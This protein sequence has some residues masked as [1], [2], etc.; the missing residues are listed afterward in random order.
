MDDGYG[1]LVHEETNRY[2]CDPYE[3]DGREA[4]DL[5]PVAA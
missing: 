4:D 2:G 3:V 1:D 5:Y